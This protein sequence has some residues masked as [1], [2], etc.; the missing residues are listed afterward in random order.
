MIPA[1]ERTKNEEENLRRE[2]RVTIALGRLKESEQRRRQILMEELDGRDAE[3]YDAREAIKG[4]ERKAPCRQSSNSSRLGC[5]CSVV[6]SLPPISICFLLLLLLLP[7]HHFFSNKHQVLVPAPA[8]SYHTHPPNACSSSS[9]SSSSP[10]SSP[11]FNL[12]PREQ[13]AISC[14]QPIKTHDMMS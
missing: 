7:H 2:V 10:S 8:P 3:L 11:T 9:P 12:S 5:C 4:I 14:K 1:T 13:Q 6:A